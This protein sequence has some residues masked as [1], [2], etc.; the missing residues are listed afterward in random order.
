M[1]QCCWRWQSLKVATSTTC[2]GNPSTRRLRKASLASHPVQAQ[3]AHQAILLDKDPIRQDIHQENQPVPQ[4]MHLDHPALSPARHL[5]PLTLAHLNK[6]PEGTD[7]ARKVVTDLTSAPVQADHTP[8]QDPPGT[9]LVVVTR[10][11]TDQAYHQDLPDLLDQP[12]QLPVHIRV[13]HLHLFPVHHQHPILVNSHKVRVEEVP[14]SD[15]ELLRDNNKM[16]PETIQLFLVN[17]IKIIP[18]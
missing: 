14:D 18:S 11:V 8:D 5:V 12:E 7:Q 13:R 16:S 3:P 4:D 15:Q 10:E 6:L 2:Q 17:P 1:L 9:Q